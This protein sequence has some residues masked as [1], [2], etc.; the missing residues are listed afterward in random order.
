[1]IVNFKFWASVIPEN[2]MNRNKN[3]D[4]MFFFD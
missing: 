2:I 1:L 3:A 4:F